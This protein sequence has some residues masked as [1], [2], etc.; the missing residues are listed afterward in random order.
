MALYLLIL[1]LNEQAYT[2][3][4]I[5]QNCIDFTVN[6]NSFLCP[7]FYLGQKSAYLNSRQDHCMNFSVTKA[8]P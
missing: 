8:F 6:V 4:N 2:I 5:L 3:P 1:L 7:I